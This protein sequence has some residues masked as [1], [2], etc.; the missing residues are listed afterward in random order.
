MCVCLFYS[1]VQQQTPGPSSCN[2]PQPGTSEDT[3]TT[4]VQESGN[5]GT[6][7]N[8]NSGTIQQSPEQ[9]QTEEP[10]NVA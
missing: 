2:Q 4:T 8:S 10:A 5:E 3:E 9:H 1:N 6:L 7:S